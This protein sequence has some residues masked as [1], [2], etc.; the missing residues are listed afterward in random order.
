MVVALGPP[1]ARTAQHPPLPPRGGGGR[2][3]TCSLRAGLGGGAPGEG[4]AAGSDPGGQDGFFRITSLLDSSRWVHGLGP[5]WF[6]G[7]WGAPE[8]CQRVLRAGGLPRDGKRRWQ[9]HCKVWAPCSAGGSGRLRRARG[10]P[11]PGPGTALCPP[12]QPLAISLLSRL[13]QAL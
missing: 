6:L 12:P 1:P 9:W 2:S 3:P 8:G 5:C 10:L 13:F 11:F 7:F 4:E